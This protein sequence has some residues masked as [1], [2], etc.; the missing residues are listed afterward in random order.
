MK[1]VIKNDPAEI[2]ISAVD[3]EIANLNKWEGL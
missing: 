3:L 1:K 2:C